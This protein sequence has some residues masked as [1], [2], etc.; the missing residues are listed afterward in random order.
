M[1]CGAGKVQPLQ[2]VQ[3]DAVGPDPKIQARVRELKIGQTA[4]AVRC[5]QHQ[6]QPPQQN[7]A[8]QEDCT[9]S[10]GGGDSSNKTCTVEVAGKGAEKSEPAKGEKQDDGRQPPPVSGD[11]AAL[12]AAIILV[13]SLNVP[14]DPM[15]SFHSYAEDDQLVLQSQEAQAPS[16]SSQPSKANAEVKVYVS[17]ECLAQNPRQARPPNR[18]MHERNIKRVAKFSDDACAYTQDLKSEIDKRR[19]YDASL[20]EVELPP[21]E[22]I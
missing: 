6:Q 18:R 1:G 10:R 3:F 21:G 4:A 9:D 5:H 2:W 12:A 22:P 7:Q 13:G 11:D 14:D 19:T 16:K 8:P 20:L 17:Q 15:A